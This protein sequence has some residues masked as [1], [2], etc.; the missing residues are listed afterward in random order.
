[1]NTLLNLNVREKYGI[2]YHLESHYQS[3]T[4][5]GLFQIYIG[6]DKAQLEKG[7]SLVRKEMKSCM[8]NSLGV[9]KLHSAKEQ[10]KGHIALSSEGGVNV[11][12]SMAKSLLLFNK[13]EPMTD[14]LQR[15]DAIQ[16]SE[17]LEVANEV[18]NDSKLFQ[19]LYT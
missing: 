15:I 17:V 16:S 7:L 5:C 6:T 9:R 10:L 12:L 2:G 18:W 13:I 8:T 14:V 19:L 4:D 1:M 11:M 3:F